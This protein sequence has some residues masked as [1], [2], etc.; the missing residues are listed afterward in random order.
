MGNEGPASL[1]LYPAAYTE[2][3]GITAVDKSNV[4]YRWANQGDYVD[5]GAFGVSVNAAH[6]NGKTIGKREPLWLHR[7]PPLVCVLFARK[8]KGT[9]PC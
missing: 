5:F 7:A 6:P 3:L 2:T 4:I 1:P 9:L 8:T